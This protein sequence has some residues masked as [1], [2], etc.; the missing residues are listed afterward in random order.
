MSRYLNQINTSDGQSFSL[1]AFEQFKRLAES[2]N[3]LVGRE[4]PPDLSTHVGQREYVGIDRF[5]DLVKSPMDRHDAFR[6]GIG[7][8]DGLRR[9]R[10]SECR[11]RVS[12]EGDHKIRIQRSEFPFE[13]VL[14]RGA[15]GGSSEPIDAVLYDVAKVEVSIELSGADVLVP[16]IR[17]RDEIVTGERLKK[18]LRE[19]GVSTGQPALGKLAVDTDLIASRTFAGEWILRTQF[20]HVTFM[21]VPWILNEEDD[22]R[23]V[24]LPVVVVRV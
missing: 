4:P 14:I 19:V 9:G 16:A 18:T 5:G 23:I 7:L 2:R 6:V 15:L 11:P 21:E 1:L 22:V 20:R 13:E 10:A 17:E 24:S 8:H 3:V 12:A